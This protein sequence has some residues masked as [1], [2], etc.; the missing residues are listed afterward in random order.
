[1]DP[2]NQERIRRTVERYGAENLVVVL[3]A[4]DA[5]A[6]QT[7]AETVTTGDPAFVGPLAEVQLGLPVVHILEDEIRTQVDPAVYESRVGLVELAVDGDAV[8]DAMKQ[9][10]QRLG[11]GGGRQG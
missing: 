2:E 3:G 7:F 1:M 4:A 11:A 8:R 10:R 5:E 9:V 6:I